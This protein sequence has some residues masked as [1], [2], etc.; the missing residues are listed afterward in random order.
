MRF[1]AAFTRP[2]S[3]GQTLRGVQS[4][5]AQNNPF[6]QKNEHVQTQPQLIGGITQPSKKTT[7]IVQGTAQFVYLNNIFSFNPTSMQELRNG[8]A[9]NA[10]Q[11]SS[12]NSSDKTPNLTYA[13]NTVPSIELPL[14]LGLNYLL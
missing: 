8:M 4:L 11:K 6:I 5:P 2:T 3:H 13:Q 10:I 1:N 7:Q 12:T 14:S 9:N